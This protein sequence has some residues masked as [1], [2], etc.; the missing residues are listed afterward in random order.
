MAVPSFY[1][2]EQCSPELRAII[3]DHYELNGEFLPTVVMDEIATVAWPRYRSGD[4][5][6]I[7]CVAQALAQHDDSTELKDAFNISIGSAIFYDTLGMDARAT[8]NLM[9]RFPR[10]LL[11]LVGP[12]DWFRSFE[13]YL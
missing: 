4:D 8:A 7:R 11:E 9:R 12:V 5:S 13:K 1:G 2:L 10:N 3:E 6:M